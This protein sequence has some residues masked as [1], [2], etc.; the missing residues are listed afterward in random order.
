M[1]AEL[2]GAEGGSIEADGGP[3]GCSAERGAVGATSHARPGITLPRARGQAGSASAL[4]RNSSG[5]EG[6]VP[7]A[8]AEAAGVEMPRWVSA[9]G[10]QSSESSDGELA[11]GQPS[12][13]SAAA[14]DRA[15]S[16]LVDA[17]TSP[18]VI[19]ASTHP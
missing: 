3:N 7:P 11:G 14:F 17:A 6:L 1:D 13:P 5:A 10:W 19:A 15:A 12:T 4:A 8:A 2:A 16:G 18:A 9:S